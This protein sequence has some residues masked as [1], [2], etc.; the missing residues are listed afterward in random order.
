MAHMTSTIDADSLLDEAEFFAELEGLEQGMTVT[1]QPATSIDE[2]MPPARTRPFGK[3]ADA[4]VEGKQQTAAAPADA[5]ISRAVAVGFFVLMVMVG[6]A[7]A[8][9]VFHDRVALILSRI[10]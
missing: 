3:F 4:A 2:P 1:R 7:G 5:L 9:L 10:Q 6:A 8:A